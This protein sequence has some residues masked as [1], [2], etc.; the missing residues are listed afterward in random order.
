MASKY[1]EKVRKEYILKGYKVVKLSKL[2][3]AGW[4]DLMCL[5][6]GKALFIEVKESNDTLKPLQK[7][8][9]DQLIN[10]GFEAFCLQEGK[11]KIYPINFL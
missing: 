2:S 11:G 1:Q 4:T 6:G 9:I 8:V 5:K 10:D 3:S 7:Y